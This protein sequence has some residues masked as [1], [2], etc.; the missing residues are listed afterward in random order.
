MKAGR[1]GRANAPPA[2]TTTHPLYKGHVMATADSTVTYKDIPGFPGYRV[3]DDGSVWSCW[4][5][6]KFAGKRALSDEWFRMKPKS[7]KSGHL[8]VSLS[9]NRRHVFVH[10]LILEAFVGPCPDGMEGCHFPDRDPTNNRLDNLRWDT[11]K[12]NH[13]DAIAHGTKGSGD[14]SGRSKLTSEQVRTMRAEY[15]AGGVSHDGLARKYGVSPGNIGFILS[16][17]TWASVA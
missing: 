4:R 13:A 10:H 2:L 1:T 16:R 9:P 7:H 5:R 15:A 6:V 14:N 11:K 3:G 17:K 8:L 12:A